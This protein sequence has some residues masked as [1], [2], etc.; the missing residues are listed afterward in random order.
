MGDL[1]ELHARED[2]PKQLAVDQSSET[3]HNQSTQ[4]CVDDSIE[5]EDGRPVGIICLTNYHTL[6]VVV[7]NCGGGEGLVVVLR[8]VVHVPIV[9]RHG[10]YDEKT[11]AKQDG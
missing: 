8:V 10:R 3:A 9:A 11:Y 7:A 4:H 2:H 5:V 6:I 1:G